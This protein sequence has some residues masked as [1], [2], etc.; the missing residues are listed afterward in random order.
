MMVTIEIKKK[1]MTKIEMEV[2]GKGNKIEPINYLWN[3]ESEN[4]VYAMRDDGEDGDKEKE[5]DKDLDRDGPRWK[6]R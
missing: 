5:R 1:K 3:M 2:S 6:G 4:N